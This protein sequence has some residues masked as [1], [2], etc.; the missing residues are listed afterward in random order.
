MN[1]ITKIIIV[2][3]LVIIV[4]T[5]IALKEK[6]RP[7]SQTTNGTNTLDSNSLMQAGNNETNA[8]IPRLVD[9]GAGKCVACKMMTPVL[10]E[11]KQEYAGRLKVDF[12][13]VWENPDIAE[14]YSVK[15]IPT[16]ILFDSSGKELFRHEGFISKEDILKKFRELGVD[17]EK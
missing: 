7:N 10:D 6:N 17:I 3:V 4:G 5:V 15:I 16:Q 1:K 14:E 12:F 8:D 9:L 11:L 2:V 13:D